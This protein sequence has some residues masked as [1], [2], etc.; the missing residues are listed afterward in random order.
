MAIA[1]AEDFKFGAVLEVISSG[2]RIRVLNNSRADEFDAI[3]AGSD[4]EVT[5]YSRDASAYNLLDDGSNFKPCKEF[6]T[7]VRTY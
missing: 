3:Q 2:Q 7:L 5:V 1:T 4:A 6:L